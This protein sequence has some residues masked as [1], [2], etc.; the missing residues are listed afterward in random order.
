[1]ILDNL[2]PSGHSFGLLRDD[3]IVH[4]VEWHQHNEYELLFMEQAYGTFLIGDTVFTCNSEN[5][6]FMLLFGK[7]L[8]HSFYYEEAACSLP[9]KFNVFSLFFTEESLGKSFFDL[10]EMSKTAEFLKGA[11][12]GYIVRGGTKEKLERIIKNLYA[13]EGIIRLQLFLKILTVLTESNELSTI[14]GSAPP[15]GNQYRNE[16]INTIVHWIYSNYNRDLTVPE[17]ALQIHMSPQALT[18]YFKKTT[19]QTFLK[20]VNQLRVSKVCEQLLTTDDDITSIAFRNGFN[21]LSNFNRR[22]KQIK[23]MSPREFRNSGY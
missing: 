12:R 2:K 19:G 10:P 21:N 4:K 17:A 16:R 13:S 20:F 8:P 23:K 22:F 1:M 9:K 14:S 3:S 11:S 5:D 15:D 6:S 7:N 18:L